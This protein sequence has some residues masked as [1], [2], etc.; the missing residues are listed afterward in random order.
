MIKLCMR[1]REKISKICKNSS[2]KHL[3]FLLKKKDYSALHEVIQTFNSFIIKLGNGQGMY[4]SNFDLNFSN[5]FRIHLLVLYHNLWLYFIVYDAKKCFY[6]AFD[7]PFSYDILSN[8][9]PTQIP[10]KDGS[11]VE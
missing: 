8:V 2:I 3:T 4:L 9:C 1:G 6:I 5:N 7:L 11:Q 10:V